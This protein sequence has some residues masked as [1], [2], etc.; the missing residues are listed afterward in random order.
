MRKLTRWNP[1]SD[2]ISNMKYVPCACAGGASTVSTPEGV[3][4]RKSATARYLLQRLLLN[5]LLSGGASFLVTDAILTRKHAPWEWQWEWGR[6][7]QR[8]KNSVLKSGSGSGLKVGV[9]VSWTGS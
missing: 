7:G 1:V 3:R 8:L 6:L 4:R 5:K 2:A 9:G